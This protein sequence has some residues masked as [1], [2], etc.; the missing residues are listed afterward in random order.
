MFSFYPS[1]I[2]HWFLF[3]WHFHLATSFNLQ[4]LNTLSLGDFLF[5]FCTQYIRG[6]YSCFFAIQCIAYQKLQQKIQNNLRMTRVLQ[7]SNN[8]FTSVM[9]KCLRNKPIERLNGTYQHVFIV[10]RHALDLKWPRWSWFQLN[11]IAW[12]IQQACN[13]RIQAIVQKIDA[14]E[15]FCL[16]NWATVTAEYDS[17]MA[18][19]LDSNEWF[20]EKWSSKTILSQRKYVSFFHSIQPFL[21]RLC[22]NISRNEY[23]YCMKRS[24]KALKKET[25]IQFKFWGDLKLFL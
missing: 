11:R 18:Y 9:Q 21:R 3:C 13:Y 20:S 4:L 1:H 5:Q 7:T 15:W 23:S 25:I 22:F 24:R 2:I 8:A 10:C 12:K 14:G 16:Y 17:T 6:P 19:K